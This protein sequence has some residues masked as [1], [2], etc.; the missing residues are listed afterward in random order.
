MDQADDR[1][2]V[3]LH[4]M[5]VELPIGIQQWERTGGKTQLVLI[6]IDLSAPC[7]DQAPG[8]IGDCIDYSAV[9]RYI[10][11]DVGQRG[12]VDLLETLAHDISTFCLAHFAIDKVR[13]RLRKPHVYNGLVTPSVEMIR[14]RE[15]GA[16]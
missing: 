7:P 5:R 8:D 3:S 11:D 12:H 9:V 16:R 10:R 1:M 4:D 14:H 13:V 15:G 6:D 2:T